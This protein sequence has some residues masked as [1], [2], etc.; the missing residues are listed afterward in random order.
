MTKDYHSHSNYE[1]HLPIFHCNNCAV[2]KIQLSSLSFQ[3]IN[4]NITI[5]QVAKHWK[6]CFFL[7]F[8]TISICLPY[9]L[10]CFWDKLDLQSYKDDYCLPFSRQCFLCMCLA[11]ATFF[12]WVLFLLIQNIYLKAS[13]T[14]IFMQKQSVYITTSENLWYSKIPKIASHHL[15]QRASIYY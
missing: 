10:W 7:P 5:H 6:D 1:R 13:Y 9:T 2:I 11:E 12:I 15:I 3:T 8:F 4:K 14:P